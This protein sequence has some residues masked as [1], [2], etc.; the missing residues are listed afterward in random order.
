M[1]WRER[2]RSQNVLEAV[3][4]TAVGDDRIQMKSRGSVAPDASTHRTSEQRKSWFP[5]G[6]RTGGLARGPIV[7]WSL[8]R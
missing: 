8:A 2:E 7:F 3:N 6:L 1:R 4:T 5:N